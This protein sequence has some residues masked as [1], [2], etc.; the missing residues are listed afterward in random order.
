MTSNTN[1]KEQGQNLLNILNKYQGAATSGVRTEEKKKIAEEF[2]K[3]LNV[4]PFDLL[5]YAPLSQFI[6]NNHNNDLI[7]FVEELE[8]SIHFKYIDDKE[9]INCK[10]GLKIIEHLELA[11]QQ[12]DAL[13]E[14][15]ERDIRNI[16]ELS[17]SNKKKSDKINDL[18]KNTENLQKETKELHEHNNKIMTN[19]IS[20][21]GIFAAILMGAFGSIQGFTSI[22]KN[23]YKLDLSYILIISSIGASSVILILFFLLNGIAKLTDKNLSSSS[24]ED[25]TV[26]EKHP[27]IFVT[28][29]ILILLC[30]I[31]VSIKLSNT[32]INFSMQGLWWLLPLFWLIY[33]IYAF[34]YK[35][36]VSK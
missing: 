24:K 15:Q 22:Y 25:A 2:F 4:L 34:R 11:N 13:F 9:N 30:L 21:L 18:Q 31:A 32:H 14:K 36:F 1:R 5:P 3:L 20:I 27:S 29:A 8:D 12:K 33:I 19:F 10:K 23:A 26:F 7:Y 17:N 16:K 28:H 35:I 6:F